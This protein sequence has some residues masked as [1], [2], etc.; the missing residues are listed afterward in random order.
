MNNSF[1]RWQW[2]RRES[3]R[4]LN[5]YCFN[6]KAQMPADSLIQYFY[7]LAVR[8]KDITKRYLLLKSQKLE[9][10]TVQYAF[11]HQI[12]HWIRNDTHQI[13][14]MVVT[15]GYRP[16]SAIKYSFGRHRWSDFNRLLGTLQEKGPLECFIGSGAVARLVQCQRNISDWYGKHRSTSNPIDHKNAQ[17]MYITLGMCVSAMVGSVAI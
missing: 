4:I 15:L 12:K 7:C 13:H 16:T 5:F 2:H 6:Y 17:A 11:Y 10:F 14:S 8:H 3:F 1:S 9:D